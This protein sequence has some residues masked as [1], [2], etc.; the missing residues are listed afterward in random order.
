MAY[1]QQ[2]RA[3][4]PMQ[5]GGSR[6]A[7]NLPLVDGQREWSHGV[8]DCLADPLTCVVSWF[9]PCVSYGRNRAEGAVSKDP[10]EGVISNESIIYGV[11]HCF[12]AGG[13][14]G[15]GG[16][17][18]TRGRYSIQGDGA[19]DCLLSCCCA[20]CSLTQESREIELEEQSLG[21]PG[22]GFSMFMAPQG[23]AAKNY[24]VYA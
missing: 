11:A 21:H 12:G 2:P 6:N 23:G 16:R 15:M 19:T 10:M 24:D 1:N 13:L 14:I 20:P 9:L 18:Q 5:A 4:Q 8:F 17:A 22:A 7:N 3:T